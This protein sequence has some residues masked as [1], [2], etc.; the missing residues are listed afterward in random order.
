MQVSFSVRGFCPGEGL[1]VP[2]VIGDVALDGVF[3]VGNGFE[4][5]APDTPSRDAG[6]KAF[7]R[8]QPGRLA[9]K[10]FTI[11]RRANKRNL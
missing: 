6:E 10:I 11:L 2:V 9:W 3:Q 8:V 5:A 4:D 1:Y 7:D